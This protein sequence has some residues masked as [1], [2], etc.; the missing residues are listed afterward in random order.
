MSSSR[1]GFYHQKRKTARGHKK[2]KET[3]RFDH[4]MFV[5]A[6][7]IPF[8]TFSQVL[9]IWLTKS[10]DSVSM[11]TWSAYVFSSSCWLIYAIIHKERIIM[12][13]S[14]LWVLLDSMVVM[15]ILVYR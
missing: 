5:M 2:S 10:A 8:S 3:C 4:F 13:N 6:I 7:V 12:I 11:L 15:G 9:D 14:T 1:A